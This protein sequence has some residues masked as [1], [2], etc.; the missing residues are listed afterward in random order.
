MDFLRKYKANLMIEDGTLPLESDSESALDED[1]DIKLYTIT[2]IQIP[3]YCELVVT[4]KPTICVKNG[5]FVRSYNPLVQLTSVHAAKGIVEKNVTE[6]LIC[7]ANLSNMT[8]MLPS[9]TFVARAEEITECEWN[10]LN[11]AKS[12][13]PDKDITKVTVD[14]NEWMTEG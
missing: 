11:M 3:A 5:A 10:E 2:D 13:D 8:Q 14:E 4:V 7:L 9:G 6:Y 1:I 12:Q